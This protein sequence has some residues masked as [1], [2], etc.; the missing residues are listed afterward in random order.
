MSQKQ[1]VGP[2]TRWRVKALPLQMFVGRKL[3]LCTLG[4]WVMSTM[5]SLL[6]TPLSIRLGPEVFVG[7]ITPQG[8]TMRLVARLL[9]VVMRVVAKL[10]LR[11]LL[12]LM[13]RIHPL[14]VSPRFRPWA[15]V[16]LEPLPLISMTWGLPVWNLL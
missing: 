10:G 5:F 9:V 2:L 16:M 6:R 1:E 7:T 3:H 12:S 14:L 4:G 11:Q 13:N 8:V 15:L